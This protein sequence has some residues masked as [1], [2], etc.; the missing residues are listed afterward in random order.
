MNVYQSMK[1]LAKDINESTIFDD[2][3]KALTSRLVN[4]KLSK[5]ELNVH[6]SFIYFIYLNK[7][8]EIEQ[9]L[10]LCNKYHFS[11]FETTSIAN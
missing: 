11:I 1:N 2:T 5:V 3:I 7:P 6:L 9:Y 8:Q 4:K 10:N